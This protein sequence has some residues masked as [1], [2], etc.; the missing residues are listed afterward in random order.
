MK[1][2][3]AAYFS[4][5]VWI[6]AGVDVFH[7][8]TSRC[9]VSHKQGV[10]MLNWKVWW[11]ILRWSGNY[12]SRRQFFYFDVFTLEDGTAHCLEI[13]GCDNPVMQCHV[14][15]ECNPWFW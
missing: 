7:H 15:E 3:N 14:S 12:F 5:G 6:G 1:L 8:L 11:I 4:R 9:Q 10:S 13:S 2:E